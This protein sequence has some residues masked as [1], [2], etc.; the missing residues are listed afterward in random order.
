MQPQHAIDPAHLRAPLD[1]LGVAVYAI[2]FLTAAFATRRRPAYGIAAL[3]AAVP[4]DLHRD[5]GPTTVTVSKVALVAVLAGLA[6]RRVRIAPL[7]APAARALALAGAAVAVATACSIAHAA[8]PGPV[9]R[10]TLKALGYLALFCVV[11]AAA[12][13]DP[14]DAPVRYAIAGT[15]VVVALLALA[16]EVVGAPSG[17]W[18][19]NHPIPRIAGPLEG[20]NQLAGYLGIAL[21]PITA[22]VL[23]ERRAALDRVAL[24]LAVVALV[25]TISRAGVAAA[26]LAVIVVVAVSPV[27]ARRTVGLI[28][29]AG[30]A[31]GLAVLAA[32]GYAATH[33]AAGFN[34]LARFSTLAEVPQPGSVGD[35]S[36]LWHAA[37]VLWR[38]SPF[39]GIGAGNF[40][41]ELARAGYPG[42]RTHANSLYLQALAE[43]GLV[44]LAAT[45]ALVTVSIVRFARGPFREPLVVGALGASAGLAFH[46]I[47]D[48][49]VFFPKVGEFWWIV[50]ALGAAR[51]DAARP[52]A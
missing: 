26:L 21:A 32:W 3:I 41:L 51:F 7:G 4:F 11:V 16:Q 47:F 31:I 46:Q 40:E 42:L 44:L 34:L 49:L 6:L 8:F 45:V 38:G 1:A 9:L 2:V 48:L 50:L 35:R 39:V 37:I 36:Q 12:R 19:A 15:V 20:P 30:A 33:T 52:R 17:L 28:G 29:A 27:R 14:D 43:G 10:E 24:G 5:V 22:Y 23:S 13:D 25:L 18:F